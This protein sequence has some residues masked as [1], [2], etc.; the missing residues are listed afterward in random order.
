M[1][2]PT[3]VSRGQQQA[4]PFEAAQREF[5]SLLG[6]L[7]SGREAPNRGGYFVALEASGC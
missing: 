5:D 3:R 6:R 7:F 4:D 1:A 2:L